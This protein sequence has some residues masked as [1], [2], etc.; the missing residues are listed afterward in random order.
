MSMN[1]YVCPICRDKL[2]SG[3]IHDHYVDHLENKFNSEGFITIREGKLPKRIRK[4]WRE[5]D[6][7]VLKD[8]M[9][10]KVIEVVVSEDYESQVSSKS[11]IHYKC[12]AIMEYYR[13]SE[14]IVF[15]PT[16]YLDKTL[17]PDTKT[18]FVP[19]LGYEPTSYKQIQKH[20]QEKWKNKGLIVTFWNEGILK[21]G[22]K[23]EGN[24][25]SV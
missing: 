18:S 12:K 3:N 8:L 19:E 25:P 10:E 21:R 13:P 2:N 11:P 20:F 17:L 16:D 6:L 14:I 24:K 23:R 22:K 9:L 7:F 4:I 5:P 1:K 15:E